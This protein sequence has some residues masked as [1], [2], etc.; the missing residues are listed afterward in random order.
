MLLAGRVDCVAEY[1]GRLSVIDFKGSTRPKKK[2]EIENYFL[3]ATAYAIAWQERTGIPVDNFVI[4][5]TTD[6]GITQVFEGNPMNHV[7]K[8]L[9]VIEN[10]HNNSESR[11]RHKVVN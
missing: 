9:S 2:R 4:L 5:L 6:D 11:E 10:Y 3:Q 1:K 7:K 8:L